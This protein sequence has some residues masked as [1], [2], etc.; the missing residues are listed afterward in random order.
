V[1]RI[2]TFLALILCL[3]AVAPLEGFDKVII[4]GHKLHAHTHSYVNHAFYRGFS[5]L[6]YKTYWFDDKDDVKDF[7]FANSLFL[8]VGNQDCNIPIREDCFYM[9]HNVTTEKYNQLKRDHWI[10]FQVYTDSVLS[11]SRLIKID[12]CTYY[13][14]DGRCVY[15]PWATD[16]LPDEI[17]EIKNNLDFPKTNKIWWIGTVGGGLFGNKEQLS[18]FI[19]ACNENGI[20]F[21]QRSNINPKDAIKLVQNSIFAP[22]IVGKW[23]FDNGYIPCRIFKNISYGKMG[24]TNSPRVYELFEKRIVY[25]EDTYQLFYDAKVRAESINKEEILDLMDFVKN[26]HTY[27]NRIKLL[28]DFFE[29]AKSYKG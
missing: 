12:P 27:L 21:E 2:R 7:D 25:N 16:L 24:I 9:V 29:L 4:W 10:V 20:D 6:G 15:M 23:Q 1:R 8:T 22:T 26:K 3:I 19:R 18:S 17:D 14:L 11:I 28:L 5:A 13:D